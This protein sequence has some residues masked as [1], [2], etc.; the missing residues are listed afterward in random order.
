MTH[1]A[2]PLTLYYSPFACSLATHL[3]AREAELPLELRRVELRSKRC[4]DGRSLFE[5]NPMGQVPTLVLPDG[6]VLTENLSILLWVAEHAGAGTLAPSDEAGRYELVRTLSLL[7]TELHK[8]VLAPIFHPTAPD[9]VREFARSEAQ[10]PL[11]VLDE[12]LTARPWLLGDAYT[13]ADCYLTWV[14][15]LLPHAQLP[16]ERWP[17]LDAY[18]ERA[19]KRPLAKQVF[20]LERAAHALPFAA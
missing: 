19:R 2:K 13:V 7:T 1:D 11:A 10:R 9:A 18:F 15:N 16:R 5:L 8:K 3:A 17:H 14:L 6:R 20:E 4:D 12:R